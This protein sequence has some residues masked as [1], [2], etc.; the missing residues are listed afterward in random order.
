MYIFSKIENMM[1]RLCIGLALVGGFGLIFATVLT[2]TSILLKLGRRLIDNIY[3]ASNVPEVFDWVRP[4]L[5]E[6]ELVQL[7]VGFALFAMLPLVMIRSGHVRIDLFESYFGRFGNRILDLLGNLAL[8]VIAYLL[9]TRQWYLIYKKA[10]RDDPMWGE[11]FLS[12]DW[13]E[14]GNRLRDSQESQILGLPLWP[15]YM[16]A[17]FCTV[18]FFIV[19]VFCVV[20]SIRALIQVNPIKA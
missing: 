4:I 18:I 16:V 8:A 20:R 5:G 3:G 14:I 19:A 13:S 7:A 15:T 2:C 11:M 9:M 12:G 6:E 17:E 1:N 10:R